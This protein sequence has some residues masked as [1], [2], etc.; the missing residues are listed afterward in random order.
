MTEVL[1]AGGTG[2]LGLH[3]LGELRRRGRHTRALVRDSAR[4][5]DGNL[6][7]DVLVPGD[8][9]SAPMAA[10]IDA[11]GGVE[12]VV[13][14]AGAP[15]HFGRTGKRMR[16]AEVDAVGNLRLLAAAEAAG[17]ARF[18]Y[19]SI[20]N[21]ERLRG[22]GYVDAHERVADALAASPLAGTVV[23]ANGFFSG[24][25]EVL[26]LARRGRALLVGKGERCSNPI[27]EADLAVA[28][29]DALEAGTAALDVGGPETFTRR[30]ELELA[31]ATLGAPPRIR[32]VPPVALRAAARAV[33]PFDPRLG[34]MLAFLPAIHEIDMVAPSHGDHRLG[35]FLREA[36]SREPTR[37]QT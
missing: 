30:Q 17:V 15:A 19:V 7:A 14:C 2:H 33:A 5:A 26:A 21:G 25:L 12:A 11:C 1:V 18:G 34:A 4:Y 35:D 31:F 6:E 3:L 24:Y 37:A 28:L 29:L 32:S 16:F 36:A 13:S 9:V 23:R 8:L 10:L 27:H 20:L 22:L